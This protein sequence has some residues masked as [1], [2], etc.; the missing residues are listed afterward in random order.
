MHPALQKRFTLLEQRKQTF[1]TILE[2]STP[3]QHTF[4]PNSETW[5]MLEIA[6]HLIKTECGLLVPAL[7]GA[8]VGGVTLRSKLNYWGIVALFKTPL[9][10][11]VPSKARNAATPKATEQLELSQIQND[12]RDSREQL[13]AYLEQSG[14]S[15]N[16]PVT[17]HPLID[18]LTLG[19]LLGFFEVHIS[20]HQFQL[21]RLRRAPTFPA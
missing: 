6:Q 4:K 14:L 9:K 11:K 12:W 10:V 17:R 8:D 21:N 3:Q 16:K 18:P 19:Q 7:K 5:T 2:N 13:W 15:L 1:M 20:H